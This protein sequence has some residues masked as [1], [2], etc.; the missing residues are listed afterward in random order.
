MSVKWDVDWLVQALV[1]AGADP[2]ER[3]IFGT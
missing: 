1:K 3:V 2:N